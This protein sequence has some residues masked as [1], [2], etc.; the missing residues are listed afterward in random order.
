MNYIILIL[1]FQEIDF[2]IHVGLLWIDLAPYKYF[3]P[4]M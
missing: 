2:H 4:Q 1:K 3:Y